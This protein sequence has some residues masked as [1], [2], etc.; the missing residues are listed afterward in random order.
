MLLPGQLRA[1]A[2]FPP[3]PNPSHWCPAGTQR[4]FTEQFPSM[5]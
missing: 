1:L 4:K 2:L 5:E 3:A